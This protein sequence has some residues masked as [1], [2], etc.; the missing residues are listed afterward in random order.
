[1]SL[2]EEVP[3]FSIPPRPHDY[4]SST[5]PWLHFSTDPFLH[6]SISPSQVIFQSIFGAG[7]Q[8]QI[9]STLLDALSFAAARMANVVV[10]KKAPV[11]K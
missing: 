9:Y 4:Y 2:D 6:N 3:P 10:T 8:L 5:S 7:Q 1:M 11:L